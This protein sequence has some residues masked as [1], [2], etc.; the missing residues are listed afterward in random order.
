VAHAAVNE[1]AVSAARGTDADDPRLDLILF[2][3]S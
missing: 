1:A 3:T 2:I